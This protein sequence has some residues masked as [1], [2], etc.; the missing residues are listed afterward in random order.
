MAAATLIWYV[1]YGVSVYLLTYLLYLLIKA[2]KA[3][4]GICCPETPYD[5]GHLI[6]KRR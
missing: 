1:A 2:A 6:L 4:G 3:G 5:T